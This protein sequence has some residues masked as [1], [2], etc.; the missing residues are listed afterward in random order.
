MSS[1]ERETTMLDGTMPPIR[2]PGTCFPSLEFQNNAPGT[3]FDQKPVPGV[4]KNVRS[5]DS[6]LKL[7]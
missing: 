7:N 6:E 4:S 3:S 1:S 5:L 2:P